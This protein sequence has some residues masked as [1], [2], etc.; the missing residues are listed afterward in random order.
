MWESTKYLLVAGLVGISVNAGYFKSMPKLAEFGHSNHEEGRPFTSRRFVYFRKND[1]SPPN[2]DIRILKISPFLL[3]LIFNFFSGNL[4]MRY[5]AK[6][7][8]LIS[9]LF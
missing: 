9:I 2:D 4:S 3:E 6:I 8:Q 7:K 1:I 5:I